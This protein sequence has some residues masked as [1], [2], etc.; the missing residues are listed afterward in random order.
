MLNLSN[1]EFLILEMLIRDGELYG[2]EMMRKSG[3]RLKLNSIYNTLHRME[4]EKGY[5]TSRPV[6]DEKRP[7]PPRRVYRPTG[8]GVRVFEA[9][10][11][12][13]ALGTAESALGEI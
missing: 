9:A 1:L 6:T 10:V 8:N 11:E 13:A 3:D 12:L 2:L 7:G 5:V 4:H